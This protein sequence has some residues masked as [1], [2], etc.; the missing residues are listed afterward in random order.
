MFPSH[1]QL[2]QEVMA[3]DKNPDLFI[4]LRLNALFGMKDMKVPVFPSMIED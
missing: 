3:R 4:L 1:I 2:K